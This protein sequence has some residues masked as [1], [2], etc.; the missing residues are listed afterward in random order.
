VLIV[1]A[2]PARAD[3]GTIVAPVGTVRA[4]PEASA[5]VI[6]TL[7]Q[8]QSVWISADP[9]TPGWREAR[10]ADGRV[11]YI[12]E[13][14]VNDVTLAPP[15]VAPAGRPAG[16]RSMLLEE[17]LWVAGGLGAGTVGSTSAYTARAELVVSLRR[18]TLSLGYAYA[19]ESGCGQ[20]FCD[21]S[22]PQIS[23]RELS[24]RY[25]G[26]LRAPGFGMAISAGPAAIWTV[27]R[28]STLLSQ[29]GGFLG[30]TYYYGHVDR[31][32]AGA[33]VEAGLGLSSRFV[34]VGPTLHATLDPVQA[35]VGVMLDLKVGYLGEP[36]R[37]IR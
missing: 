29:S 16:P 22:L 25:G 33:T 31:F 2:G 34:S 7:A 19:S 4:R 23:N 32:T 5:D 9:V 11:G 18:G 1:L 30:T 37:S 24:L 26:H 12:A 13:A 21:V 17:P 3:S 15:T 35:S 28:G 27:R 14:E 10:L 6:A 20:L 8:R 36:D